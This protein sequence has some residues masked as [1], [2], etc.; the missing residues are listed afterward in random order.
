VSDHYAVLGVAR[1]ASQDEIKR[2]YRKLAR[3]LH[4]DVNPG[5]EERFKQVTAA[6]EVLS[7]PEKRRRYDLGGD[8][9][10]GM[11][12]FGGFGFGDIMDAFFGQTGARGPRPRRRRGQDA[13]I[14]VDLELAEAA[15]GVTREI[16]LDTAVVC[17][18]CH[19]AGTQQGTDV[20][21]CDMCGGRG[22]IQHVQRSFLGNVMTSRP[23]PQCHGFGT[24]IPHPCPE[25]SGDG[26]VQTRRTL[27]VRIPPGVDTGTRIQ[28]AGEGEVGFGGGDPA[29]LYLE[30]LVVD[31]PVFVRRGDDLHCTVTLPMTAA[32]L[33]A[34]ISLELL[35][36]VA[37]EVDV[38]PG[39]Q[40]GQEIPLVGQGVPQLRGSGRG[41]LIVHVVVETP[42]KLDDQ[43]Q[44]LLRQL[45]AL[46]E[47]ERPE[48]HFA[49]GQQ[50]FFS[51]LKDAFNGR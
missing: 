13:L 26:R 45:A 30:V 40:S 12:G 19:G 9:A 50:G 3:E 44:A 49:P 39:T 43:Q 32:A 37:T 7:D 25:C 27:S 6:Y 36:G 22:D 10:T 4:P 48:G 23:C 47:E 8:A 11:G 21:R 34:S 42:T 24:V 1:D 41:D 20:A 31:H 18:T 14:Q 2:A 17:G 5:S 29:D 33:G 51:R 38:R 35:D 15:F 16:V 46:R 28:L